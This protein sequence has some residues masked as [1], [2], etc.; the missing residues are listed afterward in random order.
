MGELKN[1]LG[2][3]GETIS[4]DDAVNVF[5]E[6]DTDGNGLISFEEFQSWYLK[7]AAVMR[8][9]VRRLFKKFRCFFILSFIVL[10]SPFFLCSILVA[11]LS[12][13]NHPQR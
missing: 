6:I 1:V 2:E 8:Q 11:A 5:K 3:L 7:S 4:H 13:V 9:D 12:L 10:L